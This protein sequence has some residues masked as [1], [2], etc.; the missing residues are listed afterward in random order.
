MY[1]KYIILAVAFIVIAYII[2]RQK[3]PVYTEVTIPIPTTPPRPD[4]L[5][6]F[7]GAYG[8]Q[9]ADTVGFINLFWED[10]FEGDVKAGNNIL[11]AKCATV[12]SCGDQVYEKFQTTGR[13][14][15]VTANATANLT[16]YFNY[17]KSI[18][19]L[20][21]VKAVT[22]FDEPN[23]NVAVGELQKGIDLIKSVAA[24]YPELVGL[25]FACI[26]A[27][28]PTPYDCIEQF[29]YVGID[30]YSQMS[31]I[32]VDGSYGALKAMLK[33]GQKTIL[34]PGGCF[35]QDPTPFLNFAEG[36]PEVAAILCFVWFDAPTPADVNAIAGHPWV[37]I[38]NP[39][40]TYKQA[41]ID[42]GKR[43]VNGT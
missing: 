22:P 17:L 31:D 21:Y 35:G 12:L 34:L 26:Y 4:L 32:L 18:G 16:A 7:F 42:M 1:Q 13:D 30:D 36:N 38:G 8:T 14:Y 2:Y 6:G 29:D 20:Q 37:G 3:H 5:I 28:Q 43:I 39:A 25:K 9:A 24:N 41:Y 11:T 33:P 27:Y 23:T 15:R 10:H 40:N 19:A